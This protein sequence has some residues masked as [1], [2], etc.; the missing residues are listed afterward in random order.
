MKCILLF[1]SI[2]SIFA[3][4]PNPKLCINCKHFKKNFWM[5]KKFGKCTLFPRENN[6][7][8]HLVDGKHD[9]QIDDYFYC[10][11]ARSFDSMCG[12]TGIFFENK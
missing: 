9:I 4:D 10:S 7:K 11:T 12:E 3:F 5:E 6:S 8:N 1:C 2:L